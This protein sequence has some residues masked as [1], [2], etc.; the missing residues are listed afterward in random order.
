LPRFFRI[1][2]LLAAG[3]GIGTTAYSHVLEANRY[4]GPPQVPSIGE[5]V[6]GFEKPASWFGLFGPAALPAPVLARLHEE[7]VK[8]LKERD[9]SSKIDELAMS[10]IANTP[11]QFSAMIRTGIEQYGRL[12]RAAG[13]Q[14]E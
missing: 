12:I 7:I 10:V 8:S 1:L 11:E 9:V 14:P 6:P 3:A 5:F 13:I 4:P 2:A